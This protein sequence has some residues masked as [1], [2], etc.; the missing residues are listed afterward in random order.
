[1][2]PLL[3]ASFLAVSRIFA[4]CLVGYWLARKGVLDAAGR[5]KLSR[6]ILWALLPALLF[7][8]LGRNASLDNLRQWATLPGIALL[9]VGIGFALGALL[10]RLAR[11]RGTGAL[12]ISL[13]RCRPRGDGRFGV[14]KLRLHPHP[15]GGGRGGHLPLVPAGPR[16]GRAWNRVHL[17]VSHRHV[18]GPLGNR[19]SLSF[20]QKPPGDIVE[21][22][23]VSARGRQPF[24]NPGR[25]IARV[26]A[27]PDRPGRS[28]RRDPRRGRTPRRRCDSVLIVG[29]R[30][31]C[32]RRGG[33]RPR[34]RGLAPGPRRRRHPPPGLSVHRHCRHAGPSH[35][36]PHPSRSHVRP[37]P[38]DRSRRTPRHQP[39]RHVP[40]P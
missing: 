38:D 25:R 1:M 33:R 39:H 5:T 23:A 26:P 27:L 2:L 37:G 18:S 17:R 11:A 14:R 30:R 3:T 13:G 36:S 16:R 34:Q 9:Y 35:A 7:A 22:M 8:K 4:V 6:V 29:P 15:I 24:G 31:Q 40:T 21:P 20:R 19:L 28:P 10:R 32:R 12:T